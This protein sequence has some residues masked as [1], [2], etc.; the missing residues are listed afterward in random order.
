M[1]LDFY[2]RRSI[3]MDTMR[4]DISYCYLILVLGFYGEQ[5]ED[6]MSGACSCLKGTGCEDVNWF[7]VVQIR[8]Q[9]WAVWI[10]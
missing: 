10:H 4:M 8:D 6:E 7:H 5:I 3:H 2:F 1:E 9:W